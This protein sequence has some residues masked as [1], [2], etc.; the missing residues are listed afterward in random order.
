MNSYL[1]ELICE[2]DKS[3]KKKTY[4]LNF[5]IDVSPTKSKIIYSIKF[6][7]CIWGFSA[8][9][10]Q[11]LKD[12]SKYNCNELYDRYFVNYIH[13]KILKNFKFINYLDN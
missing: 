6:D 5:F 1:Y 3:S 9:E 13:K 2:E 4:Q 8:R 10:K 7:E 11:I 12:P